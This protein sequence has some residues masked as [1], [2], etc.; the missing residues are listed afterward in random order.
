[1]SLP[2][3]EMKTP[4][5]TRQVRSSSRERSS[6]V[7]GQ[8]LHEQ[9]AAKNEKAF[10]KVYDSWRHTAKEIR[11]RLKT[12]C[13]PEDLDAIQCDIKSKNTGVL[14][15]Y[16]PIRRNRTTNPDIVKKMDACATLTT[17]ICELISIRLESVNGTFKDYLEKERVR[18]VLNKDEYESILGNTITET[19]NSES[20][21]GS[22]TN[23]STSSRASSRRADAEAELAANSERAKA[24]KELRA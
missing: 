24:T 20:P 9:E 13:S 16:E 3:K 22:D 7:K 5:E 11:A 10:N 1:M 18:M 23:S 6:T 15:R 4:L 12:F 19:V 2:A 21:Q 14:Q 17:E 8:E